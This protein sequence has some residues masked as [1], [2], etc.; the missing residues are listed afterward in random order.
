MLQT[1]L[2]NNPLYA[3]QCK[4]ST[5]HLLVVTIKIRRL[6]SQDRLSCCE[7]SG[8]ATKRRDFSIDFR[9]S[10]DPFDVLKYMQRNTRFQTYHVLL[11]ALLA[12]SISKTLYV[13]EE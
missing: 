11:K 3:I 12:D 13:D 9:L 10:I 6:Y 1:P 8:R 2:N 5:R 7:G 4:R